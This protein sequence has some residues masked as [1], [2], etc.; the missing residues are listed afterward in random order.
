MHIDG[1]GRIYVVE[2][3]RFGA[4]VDTGSCGLTVEQDLALDGVAVGTASSR[5]SEMTVTVSIGI[6][7]G[8]LQFPVGKR[9]RRRACARRRLTVQDAASM[10]L[11][12]LRMQSRIA[13]ASR[14]SL[15]ARKSA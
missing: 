14:S 1:K 10:R 5:C 8:Q 9:R 15:D 13:C 2:T 3:F 11:Y 12:A 6:P 4:G 7:F